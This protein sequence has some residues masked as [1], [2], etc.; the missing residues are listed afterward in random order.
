MK[1]Y[2]FTQTKQP[3]NLNVFIMG[4]IV[5]SMGTFIKN[6]TVLFSVHL[7]P[8]FTLVDYIFIHLQPH[9]AI[10]SLCPN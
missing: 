7:V 9:S 10:T 1:D 2:P 8:N 4:V 6:I 5:V 3:L